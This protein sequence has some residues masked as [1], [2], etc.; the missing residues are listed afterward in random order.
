MLPW[1]PNDEE[2][3]SPL[4]FLSAIEELIVYF[5]EKGEVL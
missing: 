5:R 3:T 4:E 1:S 2:P